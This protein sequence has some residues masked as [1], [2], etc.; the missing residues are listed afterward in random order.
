MTLTAFV[1]PKLRTL[2]TFLDKCLK[3]PV[4]ED[5]LKSNMVKVPE[6][7]SNPHQFTF[8]IFIDHCQVH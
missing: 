6:D 8:I 4:L 5:L 1:F 2:K 3:I 7:C